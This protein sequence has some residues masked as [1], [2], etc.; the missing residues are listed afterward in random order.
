MCVCVCVFPSAGFPGVVTSPASPASLGQGVAC[1]P[2]LGHGWEW[3]GA[4]LS[5]GGVWLASIFLKVALGMFGLDIGKLLG[6]LRGD[7][8]RISGWLGAD[9]CRLLVDRLL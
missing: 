2:C 3:L 7:F 6:G 9:L 5:W 4:G 1:W 8:G